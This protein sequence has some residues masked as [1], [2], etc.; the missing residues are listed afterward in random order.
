MAIKSAIQHMLLTNAAGVT[1]GAMLP[2]WARSN[3]VD[4]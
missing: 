3:A 2:S 1:G 4:R